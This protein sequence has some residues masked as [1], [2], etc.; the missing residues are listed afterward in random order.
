MLKKNYNKLCHSLPR[1]YVKTVEELNHFMSGIPA[2]Y[3]HFLSLLPSIDAINEEILGQIMGIIKEDRD[4]LEFCDILQY[5]CD[6]SSSKQY[7]ATLK[8]GT[9]CT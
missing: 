9:L 2:N 7:I 1:D 8:Q 3:V 4:A 5:L 6:D